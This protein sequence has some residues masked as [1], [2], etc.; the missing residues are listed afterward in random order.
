MEV[1]PGASAAVRNGGVGV[2]MPLM[3]SASQPSRKEWRVVSE[4]SVR[5]PGNEEMERA[6]LGQSD[7]RLIYEHG[8]EPL[9]VDFCSI[10]IEGSLDHDILQQ[11]L[12]TVA[13]QREELQQVEVDLRARV[14]ARS[15]VLALQNSFDAQ[16]KEHTNAIVNYQEQ[17]REKEEKLRELERKLDEKE[18]EVH[19]IRLDNEAAWAKEDL[20]REQSKEIQ[21]YRRERDNS[22]AERA[23]H[24][25]QIHDLREHFQDKERQY[26]ELQEQHRIAQETILYKDEQ[27]REA[28]AWMT[29]AQEMDALQSTTNHSLQ[30]ELRDRT[31]QYNQLWLG[32]QRQ[33]GDMEKLHMH[34]QQLQLELADARE[35]SGIQLD[36]PHVSHANSNDISQGRHANG[37][38][39]EVND[40]NLPKADT[41]NLQNG[42]SE[43]SGGNS[44]TQVDQVHGVA[45]APSSLFGMPTYIPTAIHPFVVHQQGVP[46]PSHVTQSHFHALPA[47][48]SIQNWQNQQAL[49][50]G[51]NAPTQNHY[52]EQT[53]ENLL[54]MD[55]HYDFEASTNG[56]V[57]PATY[58]DTASKPGK[59]A[60]NLVPTPNGEGQVHDSIDESH[61][62]PQTQ[63]NLQQISSHFIETLR[64]DTV[65][66]GND[67]EGRKANPVGVHGLENKISVEQTNVSINLSPETPTP[68]VNL[69]ES[70]D[71]S[72]PAV[73]TSAFVPTGQKSNVV[74]KSGEPHLLDERALLAS[75]ARAIGVGG[76]IRISSTLPNRLGKMLA[77]LHWHDY[78]K[79][80]GKLD[81]FVA[82][83]PDLFLIEGDYIHLREGALEVIAATA[84]VAKVA[85]AAASAPPSSYSSSVPSVA[86]TP[87]S[88]S[89]RLKKVPS[90]ESS[91]NSSN[92]VSHVSY[93]EIQ[94]QNFGGDSFHVAG[95]VSN[96]KIL[97]KTKHNEEL[98]GSETRPSRHSILTVGN[99]MNSN[100]NEL[101]QSKGAFHGRHSTNLVGKLPSR[102]MGASSGQRR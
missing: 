87:M 99:G 100:R 95:G 55:S 10:T 77:P 51:E 29:R 67:I 75:I 19:A 70:S 56:Q 85:A 54:R 84:A 43:S 27:L 7:E 76:R 52:A 97:S 91:V 44:L 1:A 15:E 49:P 63:P 72:S 38:P 53:E 34:I 79:M 17:L 20:L 59:D 30:A 33:F 13:K 101:S 78:K 88:Q 36:E 5:N 73:L 83:H 96:V 8:R 41:S 14:I 21:S 26:V 22:E 80:Y 24:I 93:M 3:S 82:N 46:H 64:L 4:Q 92:S 31:E 40:S 86:L 28:Q 90:M 18:R 6:K 62:K 35:K 58:V 50:D 12:H 69:C 65:E 61:G 42:N 94:N 39:L 2:S 60:N 32:Y 57:I 47:M 68:T 25:K 9:D 74:V 37:S 23:Q 45:F 16:L 11:R 89:Y 48:S 81:D 71:A 66:H 98:N 102:S